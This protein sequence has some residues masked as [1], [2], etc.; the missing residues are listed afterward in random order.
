MV[1]HVDDSNFFEHII[2]HKRI[3]WFFFRKGQE[4]ST[5][6]LKPFIDGLESVNSEFSKQMSGVTI[7]QSYIE[8]NPKVLE[9]FNLM[10][11]NIWNY[12]SK[13]FNPRIISVVN[14]QKYY[15][16]SG[17]KCYCLE[18]LIEMTFDIYPELILKP[19]SE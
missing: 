11:G 19:T 8:D 14:G 9:Y 5:L 6:S 16:Q 7:F 12:K 10:D 18:T 17:K 2:T 13:V 3:I 1:Y 4:S 15:D